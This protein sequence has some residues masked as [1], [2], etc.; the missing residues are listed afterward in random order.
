MSGAVVGSGRTVLPVSLCPPIDRGRRFQQVPARCSASRLPSAPWENSICL[1]SR[2]IFAVIPA[3]WAGQPR[4]S[5]PEAV[6]DCKLDPAGEGTDRLE[7]GLRGAAYSYMLAPVRWRSRVRLHSRLIAVRIMHQGEETIDLGK[8]LLLRLLDRDL[9]E[10]VA[11]DIL[12]IDL[13]HALAPFSVGT[14]LFAKA[15]PVPSN[16]TVEGITIQKI[17][18]QAFII[19]PRPRAKLAQ[20]AENIRVIRL[21]LSHEKQQ[22]VD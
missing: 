21:A 22:I 19:L 1:D 16:P 5:T 10:I 20:R 18:A 15:S 2:C 14:G 6:V 7:V 12:G 17:A 11:Q 4:H 13:V 9:D 8:I 3:P